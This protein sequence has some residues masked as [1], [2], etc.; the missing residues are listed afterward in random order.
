VLQTDT[1][2]ALRKNRRCSSEMLR[3]CRFTFQQQLSWDHRQEGEETFKEEDAERSGGN[4]EG[5]E[6]IPKGFGRDRGG[7]DV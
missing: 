2:A 7:I 1:I 5:V 4:F 3:R 6:T